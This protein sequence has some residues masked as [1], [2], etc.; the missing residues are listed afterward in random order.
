MTKKI[1]L[2]TYGIGGLDETKPNNNIVETLYYSDEELAELEAE[3]AKATQRQVIL[4]RLG[5]TADEAA[6]LLGAN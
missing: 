1:K 4:D 3:A 2:V 5:L 6:L